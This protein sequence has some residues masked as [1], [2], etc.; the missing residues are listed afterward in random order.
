[1]PI[2]RHPKP[3]TLN[4]HFGYALSSSRDHTRLFHPVHPLHRIH[5]RSLQRR[6]LFQIQHQPERRVPIQIIPMQPLT[7]Y[8]TQSLVQLQARRIRNLRLEHDFIRIARRHGLDGHFHELGRDAAAAVWFL[9]SEHGD[10]AAESAGAVGFEFADYH[11]D[12]G[13]GCWVEGLDKS[14]IYE[15]VMRAIRREGI[16]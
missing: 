12:E 8:E 4:S 14:V 5:I 9:D 3:I 10:V 13:G 11:A 2:P 1:M 16:G 6:S 7:P 15:L